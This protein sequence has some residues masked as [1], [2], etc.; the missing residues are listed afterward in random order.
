MTPFRAELH[1]FEGAI[2]LRRVGVECMMDFSY[3]RPPKPIASVSANV[4]GEEATGDD[5]VLACHVIPAGS[6]DSSPWFRV[7]NLSK[8]RDRERQTGNLSFMYPR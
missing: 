1:G 7:P 3:S 5:A 8:I 4:C 6:C 2:S